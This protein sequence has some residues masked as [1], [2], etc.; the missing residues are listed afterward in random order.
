VLKRGVKMAGKEYC[1][2]AA[3]ITPMSRLP[4]I[5][6]TVEEIFERT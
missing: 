2:T 5:S 6:S 1:T 4:L 3:V